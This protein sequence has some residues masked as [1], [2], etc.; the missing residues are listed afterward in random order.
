LEKIPVPVDDDGLRTD[1]LDRVDAGAVLVTPAHQLPTGA[2]LAPQR[3]AALLDWAARRRALIIEDDY[4]AEYRYDREPIGSLQGLAPELVVYLGT[5]SKTLS[6]ALRL[7]WI[8]LPSHLVDAVGRAKFDADLGSPALEQLALADFLD[9]GELDRHLRR[10]RLIYRG[11][12]DRL[13]AALGIH[14][15]RLRPRGVAAGLHLMIELDRRADEQMI[16][17][18]A[19]SRSIR[20]QGASTYRAIPAVGP[21]AL[22][23]GYGGIEESA[24]AEGVRQLAPLLRERDAG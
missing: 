20:I 17:A 4:D 5:A 13:I 15:P 10:T 1:I 18:T 12:R 6:P 22:L 11:R 8:A 2:V 24:I 3:R 7:A 14:L 23:M 19:A 16:V 21:P 9:C